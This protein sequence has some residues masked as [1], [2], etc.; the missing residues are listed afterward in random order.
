MRQVNNMLNEDKSRYLFGILSSVPREAR[1]V[2]R[3]A[4]AAT[5][6]GP[7]VV[8]RPP[9][10]GSRPTAPHSLVLRAVVVRAA[11]SIPSYR[12]PLGGSVVASPRVATTGDPVASK[13]P[14]RP[15][16]AW[17]ERAS[18]E[19]RTPPLRRRAWPATD[20]RVRTTG[21]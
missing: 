2:R 10:A 9:S 6:T 18:A 19:R 5:L 17:A 12:R 1:I 7:A 15:E 20:T 13:W 21:H 11:R 14:A 8:A 3:G 4:T 16:P